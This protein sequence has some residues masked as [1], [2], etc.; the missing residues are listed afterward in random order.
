MAL[1][2]R[3][4]P[5][6]G[7]RRTLV[8]EAGRGLHTEKGAMTPNMPNMEQEQGK[9]V[10]TA[11]RRH[12]D[13]LTVKF[14]ATSPNHRLVSMAVIGVTSLIQINSQ[15]VSEGTHFNCIP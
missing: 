14:K 15:R 9:A 2:F 12:P 7:Q 8:I 13:A 6:S 5:P 11:G 3:P 10:R 4:S 1:D